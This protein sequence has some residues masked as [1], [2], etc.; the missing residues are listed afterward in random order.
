[1]ALALTAN[2]LCTQK[3]VVSHPPRLAHRWR[4]ADDNR[5]IG[6]AY[7]I[8]RGDVGQPLGTAQRDTGL[9]PVDPQL[10]EGNPPGSLVAHPLITLA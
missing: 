4:R 3:A 8:Q 5:W 10:V 1:M 7:A 9:A 2:P 6:D